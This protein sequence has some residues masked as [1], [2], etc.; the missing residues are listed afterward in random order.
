MNFIV[1]ARVFVEFH[2]IADAIGQP[3]YP[4]SECVNLCNKTPIDWLFN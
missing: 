2:F 3:K 4:N 1:L